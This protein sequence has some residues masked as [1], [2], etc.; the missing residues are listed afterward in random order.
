MAT[1]RYSYRLPDSCDCL[2]DKHIAG[3]LA[4]VLAA[5]TDEQ[6]ANQSESSG[7]PISK[8]T[9]SRGQ[10]IRI[11]CEK[12]ERR[13]HQGHPEDERLCVRWAPPRRNPS[14][15]N[16]SSSRRPR[17]RTCAA[18]PIRLSDASVATLRYSYR[19]PDSCDCLADE[20]IAG[21]PAT[22][23]AALRDERFRLLHDVTAASHGP[24]PLLE[25]APDTKRNRPR[26]RL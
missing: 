17:P 23:L 25:S 1:S 12:T 20:H 26:T 21:E 4:T 11:R 9:D 5:L 15:T 10:A 24:H 8:S 3:E 14:G 7:G 18:R 19:L 16:F 22:A 13:H 6:M 2:A